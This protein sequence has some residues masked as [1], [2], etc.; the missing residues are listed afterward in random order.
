VQHEFLDLPAGASA[1]IWVDVIPS[2][3]FLDDIL[4]Q[5]R[6]NTKTVKTF[7]DKTNTAVLALYPPGRSEAGGGKRSFLLAGRGADYPVFLSSVFMAFDPAWKKKKSPEGKKYWASKKNMLSF[8]IQKREAYVSDGELFFDWG[9]A[10]SPASFWDFNEG[11]QMAAWITDIRPLNNALAR[12]DIPITI[13][14]AALFIAG[15]RQGEDWQA[16]FR[17]E[18]PSPAQARG[19][20]S[21]LLLLRKALDGNY[22]KD[23][24]SVKFARFLLSE[25]PELD[26]RAIILKSPPITRTQ[27]AGL[28]ELLSVYLNKK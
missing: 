26:G 5:K 24:N 18:T 23:A 9:G 22:I 13:P 28:T 25:S 17:M 12:M 8:F 4:S 16:V 14:A 11:A 20:A 27:L 19:L 15:F 21:I 7:L 2:R 10:E 3:E 1:Y 6:L